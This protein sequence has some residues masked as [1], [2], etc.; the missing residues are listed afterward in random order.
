MD[1]K[2]IREQLQQERSELC[3][4]NGDF[5]RICWLG[6]AITHLDFCVDRQLGGTQ[7]KRYERRTGRSTLEVY[8]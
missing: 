1:F 8:S 4:A 2:Q 3:A 7:W 5:D 6:N